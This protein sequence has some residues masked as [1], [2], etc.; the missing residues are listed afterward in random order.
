MLYP[1]FGPKNTNSILLFLH[2]KT[3]QRVFLAFQV[4]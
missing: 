3:I 4:I 2:I 1:N